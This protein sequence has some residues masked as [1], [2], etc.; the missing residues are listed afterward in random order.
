MLSIFMGLFACSDYS[1][2]E[3]KPYPEEGTDTAEEE[4]FVPSEN[5]DILIEPNPIDFGY[6]LKDCPTD[7]ID[8]TITNIG[9]ADLEISNIYLDGDGNSAFSTTYNG[10]AITLAQNESTTFGVYFYPTLYRDYDIDLKVDS[11]DPE[12]P[13]AIADVFGVGSE[14]ALM[15]E[16]FNQEFNSNVDVLWVID[17]SCSMVDNVENVRDNFSNFLSSFLN[18]GL[19][20]QMAIVTTDTADNGIFQGP[21]MNSSQG[22]SSIENTFNQTIHSAH[23][24]IK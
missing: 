20:Y 21:I 3:G 8:V 6:I 16:A 14:G 10:S 7:P 2:E 5:A 22:Q 13:T 4:I 17:N 1:F 15:E 11:N 24:S 19:N 23:S 18:L 12:D 9:K